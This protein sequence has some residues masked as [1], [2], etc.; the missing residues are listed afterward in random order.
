MCTLCHS[1]E[2]ERSSSA[3]LLL[4][5]N[6]EPTTKVMAD[7][8]IEGRSSLLEGMLKKYPEKVSI[9]SV[10]HFRLAIKHKAALQTAL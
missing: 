8:T 1:A 6:T 10:S 7:L 9:E 2:V 4:G 5:L 3:D